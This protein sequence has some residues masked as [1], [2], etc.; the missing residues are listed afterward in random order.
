MPQLLSLALDSSG[1]IGIALPGWRTPR[2]LQVLHP[3]G[4]FCISTALH[5]VRVGAAK[6]VGHPGSRITGR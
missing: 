5:S 4:V 6:M 3:G 1:P 2:V